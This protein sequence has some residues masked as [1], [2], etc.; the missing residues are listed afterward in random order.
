M[1][2]KRNKFFNDKTKKKKIICSILT[3]II[4]VAVTAG[5][6]AITNQE[7]L[8]EGYIYVDHV[9]RGKNT[10]I[11]MDAAKV[12]VDGIDV[13]HHNGWI[14]WKKVAE[15][16]KIQFVYI[17]ATQG[18]GFTD[19]MYKRNFREARKAGLNVGAYHFFTSKKSGKL[20]F[21]YFKSIV[22]RN[23]GNIIPMVDV[24]Y[25]RGNSGMT[26]SQLQS[27]LTVFCE[28]I[29]KEYGRKPIIYTSSAIYN[30]MLGGKFDSYYIWIARY[31]ITPNLKSNRKHHVWQFTEHG[32][33]DGIDYNV[34]L[35]RFES[36][37]TI[38]E[39]KF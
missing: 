5:V 28:L 7:L 26:A 18:V 34:D 12:R 39:L 8:K 15:N 24:E 3:P 2:S 23:P 36:G 20:Q 30:K 32:I 29:K 25:A 38:E 16:P 14:D 37:M 6:I 17:K 33:V 21:N 31:G 11:G 9:L 13:S 4:L 35:N 10:G 27:E 22:G 1:F 19:P